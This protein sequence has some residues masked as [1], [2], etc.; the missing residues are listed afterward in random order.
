MCRRLITAVIT[1]CLAGVPSIYSQTT[2]PT[3]SQ[4]EAKK[5]LDE[6]ARSYRE[7]QFEDAQRHSERALTLDPD[8]KTAPVFIARTIHAQFK[9]G[10]FTPQNIARAQDA[11]AAYQRVLSKDP[12]NEEAYKA[13]A[14]I[15]SQLKED[16]L[17]Q[18]WVLQ[19]ASDGSI[20]K[21]K[22]SEA[23]V[24]LAS[25]QWDCS[26]K[27]TELPTHKTTTS[28]SL[29]V[30]VKYYK[31]DDEVAFENARQCALRGL[32]LADLAISL[33]D[34]SE[35]AWSYKTNLL[36]EL[37]KF[38]E[39]SGDVQQTADFQRQYKAALKETT[40]LAKAREEMEKRDAKDDR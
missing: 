1:V 9:R 5:E 31:S 30:I 33:K 39:M 38:A 25:K 32:E 18:N 29:G 34:V 35:S 26:F 15:Y 36:L 14:W 13:I 20:D 23:Y 28:G 12:Q 19:R 22:R 27:F 8:N 2:L 7:A 10:D 40:K 4:Q 21:E 3:Q 24:V 6:A 17:L 37:S 16:D 11:I